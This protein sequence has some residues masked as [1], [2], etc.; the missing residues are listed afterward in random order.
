MSSCLS[1]LSN[2]SNKSRRCDHIRLQ[3]VLKISRKA[4]TAP[5][6]LQLPVAQVYGDNTEIQD[7]TIVMTI[8]HGH[9]L[10]Q[11]DDVG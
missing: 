9:L 10:I 6:L 1:T 5:L 2:V 3:L 7:D 11:L 4:P 8:V